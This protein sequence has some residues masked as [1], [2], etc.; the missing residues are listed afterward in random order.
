MNNEEKLL[1]LNNKIE[2]LTG[3]LHAE[4]LSEYQL[5][6]IMYRLDNLTITRDLLQNKINREYKENNKSIIDIVV[7][8]ICYTIT[9]IYL[10]ILIYLIA[11][12]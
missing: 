3:Q 7:F 9:L 5:K 12:F 8:Y 10:L 1:E 2:L 11:S 6:G 4:Y